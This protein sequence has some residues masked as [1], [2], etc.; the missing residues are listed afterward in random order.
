MLPFWESLLWITLQPLKINTMI[1]KAATALCLLSIHLQGKKGRFFSP[2]IFIIL[3]AL[4]VICVWISNEG[5][6]TLKGQVWCLIHNIWLP[7]II[8]LIQVV[9]YIHPSCLIF[10]KMSPS[11]YED[12]TQESAFESVKDPQVNSQNLIS[13]D[14]SIKWFSST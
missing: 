14:G 9:I 3:Y 11:C 8:G 1:F 5:E 2:C 12:L 10:I 7:S 13:I 6:S 4:C